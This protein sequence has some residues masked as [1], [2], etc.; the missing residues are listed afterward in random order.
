MELSHRKINKT[1][2]LKDS[3]GRPIA[4]EKVHIEQMN[5]SFLF[6][7]G[8][9]D[10]MTYV[11]NGGAEYQQLTDS[12]LDIFNY[13]T[14]PFYWGNYELEEGK[15]NKEVM[16]ETARYLKGRN[17]RVKGHPYEIR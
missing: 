10:F 6:G 9:F 17:V 8:A 11:L 13:A 4:N 1:L 7:C 5:H 16:M 15:P 14:L 12:W 3:K 2:L